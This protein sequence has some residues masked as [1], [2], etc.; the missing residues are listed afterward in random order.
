MAKAEVDLSVDDAIA[1]VKLIN[2]MGD[3]AYICQRSGGTLSV[4]SEHTIRYWENRDAQV[5]EI[6]RVAR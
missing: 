1:R 5:I 2:S 6:C 4:L 3:T